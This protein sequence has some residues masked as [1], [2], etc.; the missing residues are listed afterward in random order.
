MHTCLSCDCFLIVHYIIDQALDQVSMTHGLKR[1]GSRA[2]LLY[3]PEQLEPL[4]L[5]LVIDPRAEVSLDLLKKSR[6]THAEY[7][8]VFEAL[9][10]KYIRYDPLIGWT[11]PRT[12]K[13]RR[14]DEADRSGSAAGDG[15]GAMTGRDVSEEV[16]ADIPATELGTASRQA[17][18]T[19]SADG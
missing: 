18:T 7:E 5:L 12:S 13:R 2:N 17:E 9:S 1:G 14:V 15:D 19:V 4:G 3:N 8:A 6:K 11:P 16:V 10:A